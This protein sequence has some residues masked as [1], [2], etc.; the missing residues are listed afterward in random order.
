LFRS[1]FFFRTTQE[2]E[3]LFFLSR[4]VQIFFP[5]FNI[6]LYDK[7]SESDYFFF[8][9]PKSEYFFQQHWESEWFFLEKNH[10]PSLQV[11]WS[12]PYLNLIWFELNIQI[13]KEIYLINKSTISSNTMLN[14]KHCFQN[15]RLNLTFSLKNVHYLGTTQLRPTPFSSPTA[16]QLF[17]PSITTIYNPFH[18]PSLPLYLPADSI[19]KTRI[20]VRVS[21]AGLTMFPVQHRVTGNCTFVY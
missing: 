19:S 2:L 4:E 3:Y 5:K 18:H 12:F 17:P 10:N 13:N 20:K 8:P 14:W 11:K 15:R 7:N 9:P 6:R 21:W 16:Q 1:E